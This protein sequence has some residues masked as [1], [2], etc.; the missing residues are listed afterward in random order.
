MFIRRQQQHKRGSSTT[1]SRLVTSASTSR[2]PD[3][4]VTTT[5]RT[6]KRVIIIFHCEFS[7]ERGPSLLRF[8]RNQDRALNQDVYPYLHYPELYL[9]EGGYKSFYENFKVSFIC[10]TLSLI[11]QGSKFKWQLSKKFYTRA[12]LSTLEYYQIW[13]YRLLKIFNN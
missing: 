10:L 9:L 11:N 7:S 2:L 4:P 12:F 5:M 6:N 1:T 8:L 3:R 13:W